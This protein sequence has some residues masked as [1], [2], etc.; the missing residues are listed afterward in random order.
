M[1]LF[2]ER[3]VRTWG[4]VRCDL[5]WWV[6]RSAGSVDSPGGV[7]V[8]NANSRPRSRTARTYP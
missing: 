4:A 2:G 7:G 5:D 3:W 8:K 6:A 1:G